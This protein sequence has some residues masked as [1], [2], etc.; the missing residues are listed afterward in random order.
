MEEL[1]RLPPVFDPPLM[2]AAGT[3]GFA[4]D[5]RKLLDWAQ[6]GAFVTNPIS[7]SPRRP[8][9]STR[10]RVDA[11]IALVHTGHPNPGFHKVL[12]Q[13]A[14]IWAQADLPVVVHLLAGPPAE[15]RKIIPRLEVL[16]NVTAV[17]LGFPERIGRSE[18]REVISASLGELPILVSLPLSRAV[19]LAP[20][21]VESGA[22]AVA[23]SPPRGQHPNTSGS[24]DQGRL[25]GPPVFPLALHVV[26][27]MS[28]AQVP[29]IGAGGVYSNEQAKAMRQAGALAVQVDL[30]LWRG[31]WFSSEME[32]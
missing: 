28:L 1:L 13:F 6:F 3:L 25:Y 23:L 4:P 18:L 9:S 20:V 17:E 31:D 11:G 7:Y 21:A 5:R 19:E 32:E 26:R 10:W 24:F 29:V 16:E 22:A 8:A 12:R 15:M 27:Q 2:N 14:P 30:A